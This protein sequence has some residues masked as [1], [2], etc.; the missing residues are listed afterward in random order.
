MSEIDQIIKI[1]DG[2]LD[3]L[4]KNL[5]DLKSRISP[6]ENDYNKILETKEILLGNQVR[7]YRS[8]FHTRDEVINCVRDNPGLNGISI[9]KKLGATNR[10]ASIYSTL[11]TLVQSNKLN[12]DID[13]RYFIKE[14]I[15]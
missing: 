15:L 1:L 10:E 5:L 9:I 2:K 7:S 12:K 14:Y 4:N 11:S 6:I 3:K 13:K 8:K